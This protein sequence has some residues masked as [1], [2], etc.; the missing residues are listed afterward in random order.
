MTRSFHTDDRSVSIAVTHVLAIGITTLLIST[1]LLGTSGLLDDQ[2]EE[3]ARQELNTVGNRLAEQISEASNAATAPGGGETSFRVTQP[4]QV[5]DSSYSVDLAAGSECDFPNR[6]LNEVPDHCLVLELSNRNVEV[7]VPVHSPNAD[8]SLT[9]T[10]SGTFVIE[11]VPTID[12]KEFEVEDNTGLGTTRY[13]LSWDVDGAD[14]VSL[15]V[16]RSGGVTEEV[17]NKDET[18]LPET[19]QHSNGGSPENHRFI[20]EAS[21]GATTECRVIGDNPGGGENYDL[22]DASTC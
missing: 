18:F 7:Q 9:Q 21:N 14:S 13:L 17:F 22:S 4:R 11:A 8:V 20:L 3:A 1:L 12:F 19:H 2:R 6:P 16:E 5:A 15:T 10:G